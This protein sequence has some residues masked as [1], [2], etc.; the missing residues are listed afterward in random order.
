MTYFLIEL[1]RFHKFGLALSAILIL[2]MWIEA[3]TF[4]LAWAL[5]TYS[6]HLPQMS[7]SHFL[8]EGL[9]LNIPRS[10][11]TPLSNLQESLHP[12]CPATEGSP[13][14]LAIDPLKPT[15]F[16]IEPLQQPWFAE[17]TQLCLRL[18]SLN[19]ELKRPLPLIVLAELNGCELKG[20]S[21]AMELHLWCA[22]R[23]VEADVFYPRLPCIIYR[24]FNLI[25]ACRS[26][27]SKAFAINRTLHTDAYTI[28][29]V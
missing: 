9:S 8:G 1:S 3:A 22:E 29:T 16:T 10:Q 15:F 13:I 2:L 21:L 4:S 7:P 17:L 12:L 23:K 11:R 18:S 26:A 28:N 6:A 20:E 24:A 25:S 19:S 5:P 27:E 14:S